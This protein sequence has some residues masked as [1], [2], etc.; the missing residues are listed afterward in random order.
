MQNSLGDNYISDGE[1]GIHPQIVLVKNALGH[2][3]KHDALSSKWVIAFD[4]MDFL[5]EDNLRDHRLQYLNQDLVMLLRLK[6]HM[7]WSQVVYD[8]ALSSFLNTFLMYAKRVGTTRAT[9]MSS[10]FELSADLAALSLSHKTL[11]R[12]MF[13]VILRL[14]TGKESSSCGF[15]SASVH[16]DLVYGVLDLPRLLDFV[17]LYSRFNLPV[18][19]NIVHNLFTIQPKYAQEL[20]KTVLAANQVLLESFRQLSRSL[21]SALSSTPS[22]SPQNDAKDDISEENNQIDKFADMRE[23]GEDLACYLIDLLYTLSSFAKVHPQLALPFI[24]ADFIASLSYTLRA[25]LPNLRLIFGS[26]ESASTPVDAL[27]RHVATKN[28]AL[29]L[30]NKIISFSISAI[31]DDLTDGEGDSNTEASNKRKAGNIIPQLDTLISQLQALIAPDRELVE[32]VSKSSKED[33]RGFAW[34]LIEDDQQQSDHASANITASGSLNTSTGLSISSIS[35]EANTIAKDLEEKYDLS[36]LI[37]ELLDQL[38]SSSLL[39]SS[40]P[41]STAISERMSMLSG[42]R[43][44]LRGMAE[45][46]KLATS[47]SHGIRPPSSASTTLTRQQELKWQESLKKAEEIKSII[48]DFSE[49][50]LVYA[51]SKHYDNNSDRLMNDFWD[52]KW[53]AELRSMDAKMSVDSA[54][55]H[56]FGVPN[57]ILEEEAR[58]FRTGLDGSGAGSEQR[59]SKRDQRKKMKASIEEYRSTFSSGKSDAEAEAMAAL[60]MRFIAAQEKADEERSYVTQ[61]KRARGQKVDEEDEQLYEQLKASAEL[62][63]RAERGA[64]MYED[65]PDDSLDDF[66]PAMAD[67]DRDSSLLGRKGAPIRSKFSNHRQLNIPKDEEDEDEED[68]EDAGDYGQSLPGEQSRSNFGASQAPNQQRSGGHSAHGA[69]GG[70][71]KSGQNQKSARGGSGARNAGCSHQSNPQGHVQSN[72]Q[73]N[74]SGQRGGGSGGAQRGGASSSAQGSAHSGSQQGASNRG[75]NQSQSGGG[76]RGAP[77]QGNAQ[78]GQ[79]QNSGGGRGK[80]PQRG[81]K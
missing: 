23:T 26:S 38:S 63:E 58:R 71:D 5:P 3:E 51:L 73:G 33:T 74:R 35:A 27:R 61:L 14:A 37:A 25:A 48:T 1:P 6:H 64:L 69:H 65:E 39:A 52:Q 67:S 9:S 40:S 24:D 36:A 22:S 31:Q 19:A 42:I 55:M 7:F 72:T 20:H 29:S 21:Q 34:L 78:A 30:I 60:T 16:A 4:W 2:F 56:L 75:S 43:M 50:L 45:M 28:H 62:V 44:E 13:T 47:S 68:E 46:R 41:S 70:R 77:R 81:G 49:G 12:N 59:K 32:R 54:R 80:P 8:K 11:M 53:P 17:S 10:S 76:G 18:V 15:G 57:S 66:H 79:S